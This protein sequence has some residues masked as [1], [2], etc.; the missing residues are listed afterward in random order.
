M[1]TFPRRLTRKRS[2]FSAES[3][4]LLVLL[5]A[6][7]ATAWYAGH[8]LVMN[9]SG[10][11]TAAAFL[12]I[13]QSTD[14]T[15][16]VGYSSTREQDA[17]VQP[18][19]AGA[20]PYCQAGQTPTFANGI[21]ALK[22][23]VGDAMG[24]PVECEHVASVRGDTIQ[25]TST[26]LAAYNSSTNTVTFTDGWHHWALTA[27]GFVSWDGTEASPPPPTADQPDD[28]DAPPDQAQ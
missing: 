15:R 17:V 3:L 23:Q 7:V 21:A 5:A 16:Q 22:Q 11:E 12:G 1:A 25:Q 10:I 6:S 13:T 20:A 18:A 14:L 24:T 9:L 27:D 28:A 8:M 19:A 26:G 4:C 2:A